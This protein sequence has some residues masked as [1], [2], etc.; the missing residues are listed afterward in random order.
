LKHIVSKSPKKQ[1]LIKPPKEQAQKE[2]SKPFP[3]S[4]TPVMDKVRTPTAENTNGQLEPADMRRTRSLDA[5]GITKSVAGRPASSLGSVP[6]FAD[7]Q[8]KWEDSAPY[9]SGT[10]AAQAPQM[11]Q[12]TLKETSL[13]TKSRAANEPRVNT[14]DDGAPRLELT[15]GA[16]I[17]AA[18]GRNLRPRSGVWW[19]V[20]W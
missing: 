18:F 10:P 14:G 8:Q 19:S 1:A 13:M 5:S 6:S 17:R 16:R 20:L 7:R 4:V 9:N 12:N 3:G 11:Q 2:H 15:P